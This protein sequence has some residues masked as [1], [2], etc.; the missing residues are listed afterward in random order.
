M[1]ITEFELK[2]L[3]RADKGKR[4]TD[5]GSLYGKVRVDRSG[6]VNVGFEYRY[7]AGGAIRAI[8]AG[9]WPRETMP[10]IR[11]RRDALRVEV[12]KGRDPLKD[13]EAAKLS[14][15]AEQAAAIA[16]EHTRIDA[17]AAAARRMT[18][19]ELFD[20]WEKLALKTRK[21]GGTEI[22]RMFEKDVLPS[23]G[24]L[25][26]EDA[27]K[28]HVAAM[29]DKVRERGVRRMANLL[30]SLVR[31]MF[32][33]AVARD[34]IE[35]DPTASLRKAD[36]GGKEVERDRVLSE[37]EIIDLYHKLPDAG[38]SEAAEAAIWIVLST[39][40]R[41]GELCVAQWREL[42]IENRCWRIP[43]PDTKTHHEQV[44]ALSDF[45]IRHFKVLQ[46]VQTSPT[47]IFPSRSGATHLDEKTITKQIHDR[48][49]TAAMKG[50]SKRGSALQ[51]KGGPWT[52]HDLRRTGATLMGELN[53]N[54]N[55]I[56]RCL[57]HVEPNR[58]KR[59]YQRQTRIVRVAKH[60]AWRVLGDRLDV[61]TGQRQPTVAPINVRQV[62]FAR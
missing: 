5:G 23:I 54:E 58:M 49:R 25:A 16:N 35:A 21:D 12:Q 39:C 18:V 32:R 19:T 52:P 24:T 8:S 28:R 45:A 44:V 36:F 59:I 11:K 47:W 27:K 43:P 50:R 29:L 40:C 62:A 13:R 34:W 15:K 33:F 20:R 26:V 30:L 55:I 14:A 4:L 9:T 53:V 6:R 3:T 61:L 38:L 57:N 48:Q 22:R 60:E 51:L 1:P 2:A 41:I 17:L 31:Q 46:S 37:E 42:D 7:R 56:E 10:A